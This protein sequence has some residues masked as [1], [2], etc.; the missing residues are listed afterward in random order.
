MNKVAACNCEFCEI[1]KNTFFTERL[2]ATASA[3][4]CNSLRFS[5]IAPT[6][7][8]LTFEVSIKICYEEV[9]SIKYFASIFNNKLFLS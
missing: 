8:A 3:Q 2:L 5:K 7:I 9:F 1:S 4:I 6:Q